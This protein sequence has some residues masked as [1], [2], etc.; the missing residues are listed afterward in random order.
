MYSTTT[1]PI[2][3]VSN[4]FDIK[5]Q[6]AEKINLKNGVP[7]YCINA[8]TQEIVRLEIYFDA[9]IIRQSKPFQAF[10]TNHMLMEGTSNRTSAQISEEIDFYGGY[11]NVD[12]AK[13]FSTITLHILNKYLD[14]GLEV[15]KDVLLN[16]TFPQN[17]L[18]TLIRNQRSAYMV[19]IEKVSYIAQ[20]KLN[21]LLF[22]GHPYGRVSTE[23]D[24]NKITREDIIAFY[25]FYNLSAA[26]ITLSGKIGDKEI[27]LLNA[28]LGSIE[29]EKKDFAP[30]ESK[31]EIQ[32]GDHF[33]EKKDAMQSSI[34]VATHLPMK[35]SADFYG[36][37]VLNT[38]FGGYFGSRLMNNIREDKG[39]TYGI[40]SYVES[41]SVAS[42]LIVSTE[43]KG[44]I[45]E[46]AMVEIFKEMDKL[47][48]EL[49]PQE[50]LEKVRTY[51]LGKFLKN[52]DGPFELSDR[53][54]GIHQFKLGYDYY[55]KYIDTI[56]TITAEEL[57]AL[58][59]KYFVKENMVRLIAGGR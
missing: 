18:D 35:G 25:E 3:A 5:I 34:K 32:A 16:P 43:V 7:V 24:F 27:Q 47:R 4:T 58:A 29:I 50:E 23:D 45:A 1:L 44:D 17:E 49:I 33:V 53:F 37:L 38:V 52:L 22:K 19:D 8:G 11:L 57:Q 28:T 20:K 40:S 59:R 42:C 13:D 31:F 56:K 2:P 36:I 21:E 39:W 46:K 41:M 6:E 54:W 55:Q 15:L 14:K 51:M 48:E 12:Y 30:Y 10:L 9:G 26:Q